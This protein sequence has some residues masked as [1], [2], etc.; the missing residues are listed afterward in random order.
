[1]SEILSL[2]WSGLVDTYQLWVLFLAVMS[3]KAARNRGQLSRPAHIAGLPLLAFGYFWDWFVNWTAFFLL[4]LERPASGLEIVT[5]RLQRYADGS[6]CWRRRLAWWIDHNFL[7][8][9]D[10]VG[11]HVKWPEDKADPKTYLS[12]IVGDLN[13]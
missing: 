13:V 7:R 11:Y 8:H 9:F 10:P 12:H 4:F 2:A 3:L 5:A 6:D 1:M